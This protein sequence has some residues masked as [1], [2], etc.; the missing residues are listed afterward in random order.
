MLTRRRS[1]SPARRAGLTL[2]EVL[3]AAGLGVILIGAIYAAIEQSWRLTRSGR[4]ELERQQI[5][6]AVLRRIEL[7]LRGT[8]FTPQ[9]TSD[10][11]AGA[12]DD[13][14]L[15][16][17]LASA[18][19][20]SSGSVASANS[21]STGSSGSSGT[22]TGSTSGSTSSTTEEGEVAWT[23][24]LGIRGSAN[25][26]VIDVSHTKPVA[27]LDVTAS[28][29]STDLQTVT[30]GIG[31]ADAVVLAAGA[32]GPLSRPDDDGL[33]LMRRQGD[34]SSIAESGDGS[35][36]ATGTT[37]L[38]AQEISSIQ[39]RY[40]NGLSWE[41]EWDSV[42]NEALPRAVEVTIVFD[43]PPAAGRLLA[44]PVSAST[45]QYRRVIA[46]PTSDPILTEESY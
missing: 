40:F 27:V 42:T 35:G 9:T 14:G 43:P 11:E 31:N 16:S 17:A 30:Y 26:L 21:G 5:A 2:L 37:Q 33:G 29:L 28:P 36:T 15:A 46:I 41:T 13:S 12:V 8:M 6:R 4:I 3:L 34:R 10:A 1:M 39:F 22:G 25:E 23:A 19:L 7:D 44:S 24:S 20:N 45:T 38:L 32:N 18:G